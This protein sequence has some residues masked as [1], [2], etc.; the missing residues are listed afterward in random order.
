V[1]V[2]NH[3]PEG[4]NIPKEEPVSPTGQVR[5]EGAK[6]EKSY[7]LAPEVPIEGV[8]SQTSWLHKKVEDSNG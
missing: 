7:I 2:H 4:Y 5:K 8:K 1:H 6:P 3:L